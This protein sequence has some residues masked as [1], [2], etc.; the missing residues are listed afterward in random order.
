MHKALFT[1][2]VALSLSTPALRADPVTFGIIRVDSDSPSLGLSAFVVTNLTGLSNCDA[3]FNVC[4]ALTIDDGLLRID[5]ESGGSPGVAVATLPDGFGP[6]ETDPFSFPDFNFDLS[7]WNVQSVTFSGKLSPASILTY[8]GTPLTLQPQSFSITFDPGVTAYAELIAE[9]GP[10]V[11]SMPENSAFSTATLF[12][13][14]AWAT[15]LIR[16]RRQ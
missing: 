12:G 4:T 13:G 6:G 3:F 7:G 10:P 5:Y 14:V 9:A 2:A 11:V 8:S 15:M 16:K 1:L